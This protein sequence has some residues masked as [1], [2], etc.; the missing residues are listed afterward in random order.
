MG[1]N[2]IDEILAHPWF[3]DLNIEALLAKQI[4]PPYVPRVQDD[5]AYFDRNL[6]SQTEVQ[7]T[8]L[9]A[10]QRAVINKD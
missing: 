10:T 5:L 6:T 4:T 7:D 3:A 9:S 2:G 8:I 1:A